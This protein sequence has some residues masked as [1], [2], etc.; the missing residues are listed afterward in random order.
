MNQRS[1]ERNSLRKE[2]KAKDRKGWS[3]RKR[4]LWKSVYSI[5]NEIRGDEE[6]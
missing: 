6:E 5:L 1:S 3:V 4:H 2:H